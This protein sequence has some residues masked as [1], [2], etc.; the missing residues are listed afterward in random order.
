VEARSDV[1]SLVERARGAD[2]EAWETLY[3]SLYQRLLAYARH[4]LD[5]DRA[6]EA[7]SEAMTRAVAGIDRFVWKGGGFEG[8][9][10]GI[11]R[12]V[13]VDT[14]RRDGRAGAMAVADAETDWA[15]PVEGL[16]AAEE[17]CAVRAA[18][19]R[20]RAEDQELLHLRVVAGLSSEEVAAVV[21]KR[22]GAV[23]MAQSRALDRLRQLLEDSP[24]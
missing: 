15:E 9:L 7:V 2:V 8:W 10:F 20:L 22:R 16:L 13:I 21:G 12:H 3:R 17:A 14:Q 1:E 11:L 6:G 4:Q 19:G 18:F 23:R 5:A 24:A